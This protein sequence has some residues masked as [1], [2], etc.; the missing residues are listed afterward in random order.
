MK[1]QSVDKET[2]NLYQDFNIYLEHMDK[3]IDLADVKDNNERDYI[4][5]GLISKILGSSNSIR[6]LFN[7]K[8]T[9]EAEFLARS[10]LEALFYMGACINSEE[11]LKNF[12]ARDVFNQLTYIN[13]I[14]NKNHF[15]LSQTERSNLDKTKEEL[16]RLIKENHFQ[17]L[18]VE[19]A[20][21]LAN[22]PALYDTRFRTH[23]EADHSS[24][25]YLLNTYFDYD[26]FRIR[27][28]RILPNPVN[29][30]TDILYTMNVVLALSCDWYR[31]QFNIECPLE[32]SRINSKYIQSE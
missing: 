18:S 30:I 2:L 32:I 14:L 8:V 16:K 5:A 13:S 15:K 4:V 7:N 21:Q 20:S 17:Q 24:P 25:D 31:R 28:I 26:G 10:C 29:K 3:I 27:Q 6:I 9:I 19:R 1:K 12:M 23:S 22:I 11:A